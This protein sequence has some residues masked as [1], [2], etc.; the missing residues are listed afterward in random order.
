MIAP[1]AICGRSLGRS[2]WQ[3]VLRP[4]A[5][6]SSPASAGSADVFE[7]EPI[8]RWADAG[9]WRACGRS[10]DGANGISQA[11]ECLGQRRDSSGTKPE[12]GRDWGDWDPESFEVEDFAIALFR[13]ENDAT[14][15]VETTWLGFHEKPEEWFV[16]VLGTKAGLHWPDGVV[17]RE[18][19]KIPSECKLTG[20]D[21]ATPYQQSIHRFAEAIVM[22]Q[23]VPI[24]PA[25]SLTVVRMVEAAY[26]SGRVGKEVPIEVPR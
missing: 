8:A 4:R 1:F 14:L 7:D 23:P 26:V 12:H 22:D 5:L 17:V 11:G 15:F 13:F 20:V 9:S 24:P 19:N 2:A 16:R 18:Q 25:E 21:R 3:A 6:A 10:G